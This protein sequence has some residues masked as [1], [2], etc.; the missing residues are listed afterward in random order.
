MWLSEKKTE[1]D[2]YS[3]R[4]AYG[5]VTIGGLKPSVLVEGELRNAQLLCPGAA[6]VPKTG[7][8]VLV[9]RTDDGE[10]LIAGKIGGVRPESIEPGEIFITTGN[11]GLIW[12]KNT[13]EIALSGTVTIEGITKIDGELLINGTAYQPSSGS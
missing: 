9:I 2:P 1:K 11:G 5:V 8:G 13:G 7:D 12:L 3:A 10:N 6:R 4:A